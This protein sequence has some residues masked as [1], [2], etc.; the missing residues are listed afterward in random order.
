MEALDSDGNGIELIFKPFDSLGSGAKYIGDSSR[1]FEERYVQ[2]P[3]GSPYEYTKYGDF[4]YLRDNPNY[5]KVAGL[6]AY[7]NRPNAVIDYLRFTVTQANPGVFTTASVHEMVVNDLVVFDSNGTIPTGIIADKI[8]YIKTAPSTTTFTI[9]PTLGGTATEITAN[10]T[11]SVHMCLHASKVPGIPVIHHSYLARH[12]SLPFLDENN[13]TKQATKLIK[14]IGSD[15]SRDPYYGGNELEIAR[16]FAHRDKDSK[17]VF[18]QR[19][20]KG[21]R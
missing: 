19:R 21:F 15:N 9:S 14:R 13:L 8:Y 5:N 12:A 3:A 10:Q 1:T 7:F 18:R 16:F 6:I 4:I 11:G 20:T 2:A 17:D